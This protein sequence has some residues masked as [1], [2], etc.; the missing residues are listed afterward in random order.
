MTEE[1]ASFPPTPGDKLIFENDRVR[2]WSMTLPPNGMFDFHQ[3]FHDHIILWPEAGH[4]Q[5]QELGDADWSLDQIAQPGYVAFKTVGKS[6]P[7][8]PH[9][10]RNMDDRPSTH[11]IIELISE[12]SPSETDMPTVSNDLGSVTD[13]HLRY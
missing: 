4:V 6:G 11:Y 2:V 13:T 12:E 8:P 7:I 3:H 5:G 9:R 10:V 1:P